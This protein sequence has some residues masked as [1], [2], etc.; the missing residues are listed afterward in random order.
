MAR[1]HNTLL[2][3]LILSR[4]FSSPSTTILTSILSFNMDQAFSIVLLALF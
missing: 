2:H 4:H 1:L 3:K